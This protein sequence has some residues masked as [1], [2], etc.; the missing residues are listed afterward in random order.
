MTASLEANMRVRS[1]VVLAILLTYP[2]LGVA[3]TPAESSGPPRAFVDINL[4]NFTKSEAASR[5]FRS[6]FV[7]FG[8]AG[9]ARATYPKPSTTTSFPSFD[10]GGGYVTGS[11]LGLGVNVS[12]TTFEDAANL[13]TTIPHPVYLNQASTG[14][15]VTDRV[16]RRRET[17][18]NA[19]VAAFPVRTSRAEF[20]L[21]VGP[22][23]YRINAEMVET[24]TYNQSSTLTPLTNV[25]TVTGFTARTVSGGGLGFHMGTD[26]TYFFNKRMGLR[27]G[28][29]YNYAEVSVKNEPLSK[30]EQKFRTGGP[31]VFLGA[32]FRFGQ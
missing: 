16:L 12:R 6:R 26:V 3:Q 2:T 14:T 8:E 7:T 23:Y 4:I 24:V 17:A 22:T 25:I 21:F 32:R 10:I 18:I 15:G 13:G 19:Y 1:G 9:S 31:M 11:L 30:L 5:E 28:I 20:R 29:R 27:G